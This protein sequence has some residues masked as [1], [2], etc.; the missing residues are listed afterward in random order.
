[1]VVVR[2]RE[3]VWVMGVKRVMRGRRARRGRVGGGMA[4]VVVWRESRGVGCEVVDG[5]RVGIWEILRWV[6][7]KVDDSLDLMCDVIGC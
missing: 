5:R 1:M 6:E 4:G 7:M 3:G 2:A